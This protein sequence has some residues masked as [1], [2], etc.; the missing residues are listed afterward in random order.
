[1]NLNMV[2]FCVNGSFSG[3]DQCVFRADQRGASDNAV[4]YPEPATGL[5]QRFGLGGLAEVVVHGPEL[6][7]TVHVPGLEPRARA[8]H[9][10]LG[11]G[12]DPGGRVRR[13]D[14]CRQPEPDEQ[15]GGCGAKSDRDHGQSGPVLP[16]QRQ[17]RAG[18]PKAGLV[19]R[20]RVRS[21]VRYA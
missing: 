11:P 16:V 12:R 14:A 13:A 6:T 10:G 9:P 15:Q 21:C 4:G 18:Q 3:I 8:G 7:E 5:V 19:H 17:S 2:L 1:M 20:E